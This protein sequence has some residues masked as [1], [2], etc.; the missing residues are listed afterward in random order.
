VFVRQIIIYLY[1]LTNFETDGGVGGV[2]R[3][4]N[5]LLS[6]FTLFNGHFYVL[7]LVHLVNIGIGAC[8]DVVLKVFQP[9]MGIG[10]TWWR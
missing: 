6:Y 2:L 4:V 8:V 10:G 3:G 7:V 5:S 1:L 9:L